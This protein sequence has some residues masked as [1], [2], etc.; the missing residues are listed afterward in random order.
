MQTLLYVPKESSTFTAL[1]FTNHCSTALH[2]HLLYEVWKV[3]LET[4][5]CPYVTYYCFTT[6]SCG[7]DTVLRNVGN[8]LLSDAASYLKKGNLVSVTVTE[9]IFTKTRTSRRLSLK[10]FYT[11]FY[12]NATN[13]WAADT[14]SGS[15]SHDLHMW[16]YSP[17]PP[18]P[19]MKAVWYLHLRSFRSD[20]YTPLLSNDAR[21]VSSL[22]DI[23]QKIRDIEYRRH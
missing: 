18:P 20:I 12:E 9:A 5:L 23:R 19:T 15:D 10:N 4:H 6:L 2:G 17:P 16:R 11:G 1:I 8:H 14:R 13:G 22:K 21:H 3:R 7:G